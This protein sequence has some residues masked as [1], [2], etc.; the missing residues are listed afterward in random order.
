[1]VQGTWHRVSERATIEVPRANSVRIECD[2]TAGV[3]KE[4]VA[5]FIQKTDDPT[6]SL[7]RSYLFLMN[8][9]F[10]VIEWTEMIG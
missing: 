10:R 8:E 3:C 4:Y 7:E 9:L 5:K 1:M 2:R 6:G